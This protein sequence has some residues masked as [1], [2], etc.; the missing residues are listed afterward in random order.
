MSICFLMYFL[1]C[2]LGILGEGFRLAGELYA[3]EIL[4]GV[5][6]PLS[7]VLIGVLAT[8]LVQSSS[9]VTSL[10]VALVAGGL[11][12]ETALPIIFG[13]N[14][15]TTIS[16]SLISFSLLP[17]KQAFGRAFAAASVHDVFNLLCLFVLL[18][19]ELST[20]LLEHVSGVV[21]TW[22]S[23][24]FA[25]GGLTLALPAMT[26]PIVDWMSDWAHTKAPESGAYVL[27]GSA[28]L[29][30]G[31]ALFYLKSLFAQTFTD[32]A[33]RLLNSSLNQ[34]PLRAATSGTLATVFLQSS[35]A[36]T[37][38]MVP[39]AASGT[40]SLR[41]VFPIT[42]GAN[43]GTCVTALIVA[44]GLKQDQGAALQL[45]L[46]HTLFNVVGVGVFLC[47]KGLWQI[48]LQAASWL[49]KLGER[50]AIAAGAYVALIYYGLPIALLL[51]IGL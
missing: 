46:V 4:I 6:G 11:P 2:A 36:T 49:G 24:E 30:A 18:P 29:L 25:G 41:S 32:K 9:L 13:A 27:I 15:G 19:F 48:P 35:S 22:L 5:S 37:S 51:L 40:L 23:S 21:A 34:H 10:L 12:I 39:L 28:L 1:V 50:S 33:Q 38:L 26:A 20:G 3:K 16:N 44:F 47:F 7:G 31:F 14:V 43:I 42:M 8:A 17:D 45:A